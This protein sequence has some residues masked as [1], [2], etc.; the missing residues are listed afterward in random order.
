MENSALPLCGAVLIAL[1]AIGITLPHPIP[2]QFGI[3][4]G[5]ALDQFVALAALQGAIYFAAI[6]LLLRASRAPSLTLILGIAAALRL[7]PLLAPP[8]LSNDIYR[9]V[10]DGWVQ[11]AGINPYRYV[12]DDPHLAFLR[13]AAIFPN[14]NRANYAHTIYPPAAQMI[15]LAATRLAACLHIPPILGMKLAMLGCE[16]TGIAALIRILRQAG[17]PPARILIYAWNPLP[18]WEFA[19]NGHV[20]AIAIAFIGLALLFATEAKTARAAAALAAATLT[21]FLP[22]IL[23]PAIWRRGDWRFATVFACVIVLLY[24]PYL[25]AG[26]GVLG[27]LG[28]YSAEEGINS[29]SGIFLLS[30]L[31]QI[32]PLPAYAAKLYLT[33]LAG[34]LLALATPMLLARAP[35]TNPRAIAAGAMLLGGALM[36]GLSPHFPWYYAWLLLPACILPWPGIIYLAT[37]SFLLYLNPTHTK[38]FWPACLYLPFIALALR[39]S[40]PSRAPKPAL[41]LAEGNNP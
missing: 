23:L 29:G 18:V 39:D 12:P 19:G 30:A 2:G 27:F 16:A 35:R 36:L 33:L 7:I 37:A 14:I 8:F 20:D 41:T 26:A 1:T 40:W 10:W 3:G 11:A 13:D 31:G 6:F 17:L 15:F 22:L 32:L 28:G 21:K 25:G 9:Y 24:L 38:L 5:A 34:L 4:Y